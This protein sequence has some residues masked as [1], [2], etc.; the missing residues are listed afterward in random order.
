MSGKILVH[1]AERNENGFVI[2]FGYNSEE[3]VALS[4]P[5]EFDPGLLMVRLG[6]CLEVLRSGA[7]NRNPS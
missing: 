5:H 7:S 6:N 4:L 3:A 2:V 1:S